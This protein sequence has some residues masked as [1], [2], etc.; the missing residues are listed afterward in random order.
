MRVNFKVRPFRT[1]GPAVFVGVVPDGV[2]SV[3]LRTSDGS[4]S[5]LRVHSNVYAGRVSESASISF[6]SPT[7]PVTQQIPGPNFPATG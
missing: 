3:E 7:G 4:L 1:V 5:R 2:T 6:D